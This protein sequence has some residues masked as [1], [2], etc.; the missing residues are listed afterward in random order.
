MVIGRKAADTNQGHSLLCACCSKAVETFCRQNVLGFCDN[1]SRSPHKSRSD[2]KSATFVRNQIAASL[3]REESI[4]L[5]LRARGE[6]AR[7]LCGIGAIDNQLSGGLPVGMLTEF[8]GKECSG[9]TSLAL[10]Y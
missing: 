4:V 7:I 2:S 3:G 1:C 9:R 10:A 8:V 6:P 5:S